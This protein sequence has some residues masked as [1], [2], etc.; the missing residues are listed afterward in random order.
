MNWTLNLSQSTQSVPDEVNPDERPVTP[1][2]LDSIPNMLKQSYP[3][4]H[5]D[6][7]PIKKNSPLTDNSFKFAS[8]SLFSQRRLV[9]FGKPLKTDLERVTD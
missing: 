2:D 6:S 1:V 8:K 9:L 4:F 7:K 5:L 3:G